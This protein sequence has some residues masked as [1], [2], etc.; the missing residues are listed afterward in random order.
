MPSASVATTS[1][2]PSGAARWIDGGR[3]SGALHPPTVGHCVRYTYPSVPSMH[4]FGPPPVC[5]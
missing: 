3:V 1:T 4:A 2:V 5:A